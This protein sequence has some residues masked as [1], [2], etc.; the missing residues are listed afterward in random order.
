MKHLAKGRDIIIT[1]SDKGG[2]AVII[3]TK[4]YIKEANRQLSDKNRY[5]ILQTEPTLQHNK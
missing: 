4:N 5:K 1:T 3:D 2:A